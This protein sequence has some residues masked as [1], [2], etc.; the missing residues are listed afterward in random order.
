MQPQN[1]GSTNRVDFVDAL[2]G[3]ALMGVFG[4]NLLVF[5]GY[6]FLTDAQKATLPTTGIDKVIYLL[7]LIFI[8]NKF[9][10]LFS[11][12]FG[13]SFWLFLDRVS[14]R[15][16]DGTRLFYRRLWWLFVIGAIHGWLLWCVDI[17]RFYALWGV[18]LPLFVRVSN[19]K[20]LSSALFIAVLAPALIRGIHSLLAGPVPSNPAMDALALETFSSGSYM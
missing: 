18:F 15:G 6:I 12:L 5:S 17:L 2:R 14:A 1:P 7:E 3:F 9:M 8:E 16:A 19:R 13:V 11:F 20:L 4:A 10:G